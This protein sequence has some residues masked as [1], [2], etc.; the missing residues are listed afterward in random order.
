MSIADMYDA[1]L[2]G[3]PAGVAKGGLDFGMATLATFGG[4]PGLTLAT[5]YFVVDAFGGIP[6]GR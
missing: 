3:N 5:A 1:Y 2:N 4:P 6:V